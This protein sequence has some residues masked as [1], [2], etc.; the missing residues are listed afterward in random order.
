MYHRLLPPNH[1]VL[2][3]RHS[4]FQLPKKSG[5]DTSNWNIDTDF[6]TRQTE[7]ASDVFVDSSSNPKGFNAGHLR[8]PYPFKT[9]NYSE[10]IK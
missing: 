7:R 5:L 2:V 1:V 9:E 3:I 8:I 10:L 6:K 4:K